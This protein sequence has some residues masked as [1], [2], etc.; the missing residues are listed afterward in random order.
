MRG[1]RSRWNVENCVFNTLKN[2]GYQLD[3]NFGHGHENLSTNFAFLMMLAFLVD[4]VQELC[5]KLFQEARKELK[6]KYRLWEEVRIL[7][8]YFK[9]DNWE[10]LLKIIRPVQLPASVAMSNSS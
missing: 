8:K 4:Q 5:C 10:M 9:F 1:G 6:T 2:Q 3:H 7:I